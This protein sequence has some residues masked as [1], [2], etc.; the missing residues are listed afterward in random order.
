MKPSIPAFLGS[1]LL[2][3]ALGS[4]AFTQTLP[5]NTGRLVSAAAPSRL[6]LQNRLPLHR[7]DPALLQA[8]GPVDV[9]VQLPDAPLAV[10]NGE[11]ARRQ[12]GL[13]NRGQQIAHSQQIRQKQNDVLSQVL[14]L[15]GKEI[16]R[17]RIAYNAVIVRID[18]GTLP[19]LAALPGVSSVQ[20]V[21]DYRIALSQTVPYVGAAAA[22]AL[23]YDGTG[24]RVAVL[25]SG[26]DYTHRNFGGAG[27]AAAYAA[28]YGTKPADPQNKTRDRF[29]PTQKV[30][31][32]YDFVGETWAG[33]PGD[34]LEPDPDPID[35]EGHGTHVADIIAGRSQDGKHVGIAPGASLIAYKVCSAVST[36]CS[37]VAIIEAIERAL[38]PDDDGCMD[39]AVDVINMSL[40]APYG[41]REDSSAAAAAN[42]ARAGV[43]VVVAAG[44]SGDKAYVLGSPSSAP[45]VIS[46][47][48]TQVPYATAVPLEIKAPTALKGLYGN[49][50]TL[51]WAPIGAGALGNVVFVGRG[52]LIATD[53]SDPAAPAV[54]VPAGGDPY[55]ADPAGKIALIDRGDCNVSEKVR[56]ASDAGAVGVLIGLVVAGDAVSF[57]NGTQCPE[58][59]NGACKPTLIIQ[60]SLATSIKSTAG[61]RANISDDN[62]VPLVR[63]MASTSSRG[64]SYDYNQIKPD[65]GAPGS[66][67]SAE[68]G[69]GSREAAFSGTS[70]ATPIVSGAAAILLQAY[71]NRAPWAIK[72]VLM[73]T[74][75][76]DIFTN[77]ATLPDVLAPI[78][79]IGGGEV[80]VADA[81]ASTTAAWDSEQ[82]AGSLS[83]GYVNVSDRLTLRRTVRVQNY[84]RNARKYDITNDFRYRND[85]ASGAVQL[86]LP[87][88]VVVPGR[89]SETFDVIMR[90]DPA[91]L[92]TWPLNGGAL[93][94][95]GPLLQTAEVDGYIHLKDSHDDVHLAWQVLPHKSAEVRALNRQVSLVGDEPGYL[96]LQNSG[97]ALAGGIEVFALTGTSPRIPPWKLPKDGADR[98]V[99][100]LAAAGVRV[101]N[102]PNAGLLLQFAVN[103]F[104]RRAHPLYPARFQVTVDTDLDGKPDFAIYTLELGGTDTSG[105]TAVATVNLKTKDGN[106]LYY[107]DADLDS[108]NVIL[109]TPLGEPGVGLGLHLGSKFSFDVEAY[110]N[111][112]VETE[113]VLTDAIRGMVY[114]AGLPKFATDAPAGAS[115]PANSAG[116]VTV[117]ALKGGAAATP[118]Q[119]GLLLLYRDAQIE[120]ETIDVTTRKKRR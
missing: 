90:I 37:G 97:K 47:A 4:P 44:N 99:I 108:G 68:V 81:L 52:C 69:T 118:S 54:P 12:G 8:S 66:A 25:D 114:T 26:V 94:G 110:D 107:A 113:P 112:F 101:V 61:V 85:A 58:V 43:V 102:D 117:S 59:P 64:P 41:Q 76:T 34:V 98:A 70:G 30:I 111:Y 24:V 29:F 2:G 5:S 55:L 36:A 32:G 105:Q 45:E 33:N 31:D 3:A 20:K 40:G 49:T 73:N 106:V 80:R 67:I 38:D 109:S 77:P 7:L 27:T 42:A 115:L 92:P 104:G 18:A 63:S 82:K 78:T 119:S 120:A 57:S 14:A 116:F 1:L 11:N 95:T 62:V 28:A 103:T 13:L 39:D 88:Y 21:V 22:Q 10:A 6:S 87:P 17:V 56:R 72:S 100:D 71:P 93:G 51:D 16:A 79:R 83:F 96:T 86:L 84:G 60:Q 23:G 50:A 89:G 53:P 91:K 19:A 35:F 48:E 65:I 9:V 15:G 46:V 74:A 75:E